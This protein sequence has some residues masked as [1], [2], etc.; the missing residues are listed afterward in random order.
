VKQTP[1][2]KLSGEM[3]SQAPRVGDLCSCRVELTSG[4]DR[5]FVRCPRWPW[6]A[7]P[8]ERRD[9]PGRAPLSGERSGRLPT[10]ATSP[11]QALG[12]DGGAHSELGMRE[13]FFC[14]L[15]FFSQTFYSTFPPKVLIQVF[16]TFFA[17]FLRNFSQSFSSK[18]CVRLW[19]QIF[20]K[21]IF[22]PK[23][24]IKKLC[25]HFV[26]NFFG[27]IFFKLLLPKVFFQTFFKISFEIF[28]TEV[29]I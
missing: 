26:S 21:K 9:L 22:V 14:L 13:L 11:C 5:L 2:S 7:Y 12:G 25:L 16:K 27:K 8:G 23:F 20:M 6:R 10:A 19:F 4:D 29:L 24:L 17:L 18:F 3:A 1:A 28:V 15:L